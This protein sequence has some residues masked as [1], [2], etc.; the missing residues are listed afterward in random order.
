MQA[1]VRPKLLKLLGDV[2]YRDCTRHTWL[3]IEGA[4]LIKTLSK[5]YFD[6]APLT[7]YYFTLNIVRSWSE[8]MDADEK[9]HYCLGVADL[10]PILLR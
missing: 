8:K 3:Q 1:D 7:L 2:V 6:G 5:I 10:I 4:S 9:A